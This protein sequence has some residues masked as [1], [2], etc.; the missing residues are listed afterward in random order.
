MDAAVLT[1]HGGPDRLEVRKDVDDPLPQPGEVLVQVAA[2]SV[3]NTDIWSREGAYG[4]ATDPDAL[5]GW[6]GVPLDFPRIQG[7][8]IAGRIVAEG[9]GVTGLLGTRVVVDCVAGY[10]SD[11]RDASPVSLFGSERDGGFAGLVAVPADRVHDMT[12]SP[13]SDE[14]LACL[15]IAYG[16]AMGMLQR[17]DV[18]AGETVVV[19]GASGGVGLAVVQLAHALGAEVVAVTSG[20]KAPDVLA[21][22]AHHVA[23]RRAGEVH[24]QV[25]QI[26]GGH[27]GAVL[28]VVGGPD[29]TGWSGLLD[30]GGRLVVVGAIA[31]P[32]VTVDLRQLY[33]DQRRI[34]G[35]T[36]H[37]PAHFDRLVD[38][39][40]TG[41]VKPVVAE[42]YA[43]SDIRQ[44]Q[45]DFTAKGFVGKLVLRP[46]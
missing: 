5:A 14:E 39:A 18:R 16:T 35:S 31:G 1:D 43:L 6:R 25:E 33:L 10:D 40:R 27:V 45:Q 19:T 38:L 21:A 24:Q 17:G 26:A 22:G 9:D 20:D 8:D 13:L 42:T 4:T 7:G 28:D 34:I 3:N 44:A 30:S 23:D 46:D 15:P 36:M 2:S 37:T 32:L 29:F 11:R 12:G 41:A